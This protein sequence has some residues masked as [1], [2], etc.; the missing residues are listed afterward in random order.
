M[1]DQE[2]AQER[3]TVTLR[4]LANEPKFLP[5]GFYPGAEPEDLRVALQDIINDLVENIIDLAPTER[6]KPRILEMFRTLL[7]RLTQVDSEEKEQIGSYLERIMDILGI[8]SSDG[9]LNTFVYGFDVQALI[10]AR[11]GEA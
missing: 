1:S 9:L 7:D 10:Q 6:T 5:N 8:E 2:N 3:S 11:R 4:L